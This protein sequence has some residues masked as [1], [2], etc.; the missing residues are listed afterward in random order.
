MTMEGTAIS[1]TGLCTR[2]QVRELLCLRT[3]DTQY[4]D[5]IDSR[6]SHLTK[7]V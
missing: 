4:D 2:A 5:L 6:I 3:A 1:G 7:V